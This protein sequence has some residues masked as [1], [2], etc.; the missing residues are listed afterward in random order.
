MCQLKQ[1]L[2][3]NVTGYIEKWGTLNG[4]LKVPLE[5]AL[6]FRAKEKSEGKVFENVNIV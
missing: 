5:N 3:C 4:G 2:I 1:G 6:Y